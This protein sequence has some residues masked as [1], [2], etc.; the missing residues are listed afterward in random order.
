MANSSKSTLYD[1]LG[2]AS[3]VASLLSDFYER[4]FADN[5]LR[6]FFEGLAL[7]KLER[8]QTEF[9][10]AALDGPVSYTGRP[11]YE[12]HAGLG[13]KPVHLRRFLD[14]LLETMQGMEISEQDVYEI[15]SRLAIYADDITGQT[16]GLDG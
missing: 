14:H 16:A 15:S 3:G 1:R 2:G 4:V 10:A 7:D 8:I 5:E 12:V 6:G 13:I 11:L 9:F